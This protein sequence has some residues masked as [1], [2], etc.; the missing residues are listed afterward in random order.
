MKKL[1]TN[2]IRLFI[3][4]DK[5]TPNIDVKISDNDFHYLTK[6]MRSKQ[7]DSIFIFN[8][9]DGEFLATIS[10][11]EKKS[12]ILT[13]GEQ[14]SLQ[15]NVSNITLA[16]ALIKNIKI[17]TI[18][19]KATEMGVKNFQPIL[20]QHTIPD[21]LHSDRFSLNI[22]EACE[23]CQRTDIPTLK[24]V[25]K[26]DKFLKEEDKGKIYILCDE[27]LFDNDEG[28]ALKVLSNLQSKK[29]LKDKEIIVL[30]GPEGGFSKGEFESMYKKDNLHSI[31]LGQRILKAD[32][33]IISAL[34]LIGEFV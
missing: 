29:L 27:T 14:T 11:I 25:K 21:K 6:V 17:D 2:N 15:K 22:K 3:K 34:S 1:K 28:R 30:I 7:G 19:T 31:S 20:T 24:E 5:L 26:L 13:I 4:T 32:T 9:I 10:Q 16:F 23:Q 18:A 12:L 33:A 8:G